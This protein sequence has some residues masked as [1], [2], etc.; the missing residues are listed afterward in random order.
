MT[1][2]EKRIFQYILL[3]V[4]ALQNKSLVLTSVEQKQN[5]VLVCITMVIIVTCL[6]TVYIFSHDIIIALLPY[7]VLIILMFLMK[8]CKPEL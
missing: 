8:F 6:S 3:V 7:G 1:R 5:F 2:L 4:P